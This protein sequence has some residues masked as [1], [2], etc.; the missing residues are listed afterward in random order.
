[1]TQGAATVE[2]LC[3]ALAIGGAPL[4]SIARDL[5]EAMSNDKS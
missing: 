5:E 2:G 3:P 4:H 1:M